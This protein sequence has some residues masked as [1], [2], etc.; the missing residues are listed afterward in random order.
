LNGSSPNPQATAAERGREISRQLGTETPGL[1][2]LTETLWN[3][4]SADGW[5]LKQFAAIANEEQRAVASDLVLSAVEGIEVNLYELALC[6]ID[7]A[8]I[9][10]PTGGRCRGRKPP[11]RS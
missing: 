2:E 6:Q 3:S 7:L 1:A 10:G 11:S 4:Y 8:A 9:V 5:G